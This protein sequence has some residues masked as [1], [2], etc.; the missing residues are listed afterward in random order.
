MGMSQQEIYTRNNATRKVR[1]KD[2][3]SKGLCTACGKPSRPGKVNCQVCA[4]KAKKYTK[5]RPHDAV[6]YKQRRKTGKEYVD[7]YKVSKGCQQCGYRSDDAY[8]FDFH[9]LEEK[10][11]WISDQLHSALSTIKKEIAKCTVLCAFCHRHL[12]NRKE[13]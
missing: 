13:A 3:R 11:F 7:A 2:R 10:S 12:H 6:K 9:H 1:Y 5:Y 8:L 4:N